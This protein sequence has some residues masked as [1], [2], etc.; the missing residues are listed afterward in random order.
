MTVI[1]PFWAHIM[2]HVA[3]SETPD[4]HFFQSAVTVV[5]KHRHHTIVFCRQRTITTIMGSM[6]LISIRLLIFTK[7][8]IGILFGHQNRLCNRRIQATL[9]IAAAICE[10]CRSCGSC[11]IL[12]A[13][14]QKRG[15]TQLQLGVGCWILLGIRRCYYCRCYYKLPV[16]HMQPWH[17]MRPCREPTTIVAVLFLAAGQGFATANWQCA[18]AAP[19][20]ENNV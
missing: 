18:L 6:V 14:R 17:G 1:V 20:A 4:T 3:S 9:C 7:Q 5:H 11:P 2:L 15:S 13:L 8:L 19:A 10:L 16:L 12:C